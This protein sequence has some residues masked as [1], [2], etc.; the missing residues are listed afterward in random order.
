MILNEKYI[1]S[2]GSF[3]LFITNR[4]LRLFPAYWFVIVLI[5]SFSCFVGIYTH[6]RNW[7]SLNAWYQYGNELSLTSIFFL[8]LTNLFIFFQDAVMFLGLNP[9]TGNLFFSPDFLNTHPQIHTFLLIPPAWS[10]STELF[11]YLLA[12]FVLKKGL[13]LILPIM[14]LSLA[15][16][17]F[18]YS[19]GLNHD[20]WTYRFFPT[21]LIFFLLG[22]ISYRFY[23]ILVTYNLNKHFLKFVWLFIICLIIIYWNIDFEYK[24]IFFLL[25]F[26]VAMPFIFIHSK[27]NTIDNYIGNL[28]YPMYISHLF[29][30]SIVTTLKIHFLGPINLATI[31]LTVAL[32]IFINRFVVNKIEQKRQKRLKPL[33]IS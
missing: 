26:C 32:S 16:R 28:S 23:K 17:F 22:N 6:G 25:M 5:I 8:G 21:E 7:V 3:R 19:K 2:N 29:I 15:L 18:L 30:L 12:P 13:K 27:A 31:F 20:P 24:K 9:M 1:G 11:F 14:V 10:I 4:F 33:D